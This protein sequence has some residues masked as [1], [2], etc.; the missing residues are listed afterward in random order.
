M[1][2][3]FRRACVLV[4]RN[5]WQRGETLSATERNAR[6][7]AVEHALRLGTPESEINPTAALKK[8]QFQVDAAELA[9]AKEQK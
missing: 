9:R 7:Q 3:I 4:D 5:A 2:R 1:S 6:V 8:I